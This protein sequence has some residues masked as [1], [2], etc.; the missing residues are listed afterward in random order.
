MRGKSGPL[1]RRP[2]VKGL[3]AHLERHLYT[4][5]RIALLQI[6][7]LLAV[8]RRSNFEWITAEFSTTVQNY[9]LLKRTMMNRVLCSPQMQV[10]FQS[11]HR[12]GRAATFIVVGLLICY[13]GYRRV[14]GRNFAA[15]LERRRISAE[16]LH[17]RMQDGQPLNILDVRAFHK[18]LIA[19]L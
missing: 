1:S 19:P 7:A 10:I 2:S 18:R 12:V 14:L 16:A 8:G 9:A 11:V 4:Q 13:A 15:R 3:E 6:R 5:E 17:S